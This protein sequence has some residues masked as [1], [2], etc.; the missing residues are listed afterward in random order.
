MTALSPVPTA[1]P[2]TSRGTRAALRQ[3]SRE[4]LVYLHEAL[5]P[6]D[7]ARLMQ[8][9][10]SQSA[11]GR[12]VCPQKVT[13]R[14]RLRSFRG[15]VVLRSHSSDISVLNELVVWDGYGPAAR[16]LPAP[17]TIVD[18]GANTGLAAR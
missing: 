11:V 7:F 4:V 10:L 1:S 2:L 16:L 9:R 3:W 8:V 14:V 15:A 18:L 6:A 5:T 12:V 17:A 13:R